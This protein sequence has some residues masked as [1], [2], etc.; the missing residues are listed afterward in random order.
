MKKFILILFT[1]IIINVP[2][3]SQTNRILFEGCTGTWCQYCPC[4]HQ[5]LDGLVQANPTMLVFQYHGLNGD[6]W[7]DF[8][9]CEIINLLGY[10]AYPRAAF[11]RRE[12]NLNRAYWQ[13]AVDNQINIVPCINLSFT[14]SYN[15]A[16]RVLT[17]NIT[18]TSLRIIDTTTMV[19]LTLTESNLV[20]NQVSSSGCPPGGPN[21]VHKYVVRTKVLGALGD[22]LSSG[23]WPSGIVK[24]KTYNTT[25]NSGW[26]AANMDIGVFAYFATPS[27]I[28]NSQCFVLQTSKSTVVTDIKNSGEM[29]DGFNLLQ[30]YPNPFNPITNIKFTVPKDGIATL[31]V[32]DITGNEISTLCNNFLK[33]GAY[34]AGFNGNNFSSGVYFYKLTCG[35]FTDTKKM[36]LVK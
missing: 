22:T 14:K 32:Y 7:M 28:L 17:V 20:Y 25:I 11:G 16:T 8:N 19:D 21:Y 3:N 30:N 29:L 2:V 4:G 33:A 6:P 36:I 9:G 23:I 35:E 27:G 1:L 10:T 31:K 12:G 18:A 26:N 34:N 5:I 24:T 15:P 13:G